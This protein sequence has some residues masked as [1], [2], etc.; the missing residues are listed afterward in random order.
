MIGVIGPVDTKGEKGVGK[1]FRAALVECLLE[2]WEVIP[3]VLVL[4]IVGLGICLVCSMVYGLF[5]DPDG[6]HVAARLDAL[7]IDP[8]KWIHRS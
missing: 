4:F 7:S 8:E 2:A 6:V 5:C 1:A 3:Q